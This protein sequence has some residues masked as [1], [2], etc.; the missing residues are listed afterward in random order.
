M[1]IVKHNGKTVTPQQLAEN[2]KI[3]FIDMSHKTF[4]KWV[5]NMYKSIA[6]IR[7]KTRK[8]MLQYFMQSSS[9]HRPIS[10][11]NVYQGSGGILPNMNLPRPKHGQMMAKIIY[12]AMAVEKEIDLAKG[13]AKIT[14]PYGIDTDGLSARISTKHKGKTINYA[15]VLNKDTKR[16]SKYN[17]FL[18]DISGAY[19]ANMLDLLEE[20]M[21]SMSQGD[22]QIYRY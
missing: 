6:G 11:G 14:I 3:K 22:Y 17:G 10:M 18:E 21:K 2:L 20:K 9:V 16:F 12:Q 7:R 5:D 13:K 1:P 19:R 8:I 15:R 4:G